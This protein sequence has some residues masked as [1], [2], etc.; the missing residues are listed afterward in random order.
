[1][2][3]HAQDVQVAVADLDH[4]QDVESPERHRAV[5]VEEVDREHAGGLGAQELPPAAVGVPDRC[6]WFHLRA[7]L[8]SHG[9]DASAKPKTRFCSSY[10][11]AAE[12]RPVI[13][14]L[15]TA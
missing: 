12:V 6:R 15:A 14:T 10:W 1:M 2:C 3:G 9:S 7:S 13:E 8:A 11:N 4:E 5:D